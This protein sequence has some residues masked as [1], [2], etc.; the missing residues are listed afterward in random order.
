MNAVIVRH[1]RLD[2]EARIELRRAPSGRTALADLYQRAPCRV[3]F[4]DT[5]L[6]QP[7]ECVLLTTS[8]GLTAGDRTRVS[9]A[10]EPHARATLTTQAAEKIYRALPMTGDT[11]VDVAVRVGAGAWAEWLAQETLLFNGS[12]LRRSFSAEV[13]PE[14]R[15]LALESIVFGRTAMGESF[16][17]GLLHDSWR[18]RRNGRLV[19]ADTVRLDGDVRE[20][21]REPFGFGTSVAC[22]TVLYAGPDAADRLREVRHFLSAAGTLRAGATLL[23]G[24]LLVRLLADDAAELRS[25]VMQ[26]VGTIRSQ[27]ASISAKLPRVWHC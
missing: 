10:V 26:L 22:S 11:H 21:R 7:F 13:H 25:A 23:E 1:Q 6:D 15:L 24:L 27:A 4:P 18:V 20:Q 9:I 5:D 2:G 3:L 12:R 16:D 8:G 14:G 19:W 17:S